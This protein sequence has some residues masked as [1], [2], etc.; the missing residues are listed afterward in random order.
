MTRKWLDKKLVQLM[1]NKNGYLS[2]VLVYKLRQNKFPNISSYMKSR[3]ESFNG[4]TETF[5]RM[6]LNIEK[7][8]V[9]KY[10]GMP[11]KYTLGNYKSLGII[12]NIYCSSSCSAKDLD[13]VNKSKQT[14][15]KRYGSL[16][17]N[18][19]DKAKRTCLEKYGVDNPK[20]S[21]QSKKKTIE[22]CLRKY[23]VCQPT[24]LQKVIDITHQEKCILNQQ[25]TKRKNHTFNSSKKED[26]LYNL[27]CDKYGSSD[28]IRQYSENRY[29][30]NCDFYIKSIDTFIELQGMWTHGGHPYNPNSI[31]DQVKLQQWQSKANNGSR[32][33][34]NAIKVWTI[35]D[36]N[37][38]KIA[39]E[40]H[41]NY[42]EVFDSNFEILYNLS[43]L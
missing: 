10:C 22:T 29:P 16:G 36:P 30:F 12:Y 14:K 20:K 18:N 40:N 38:R 7:H 25:A 3:Y 26:K 37:K 9:C 11:T 17:Y 6:K 13:R 27:L 4:F 2:T 39:K 24:Q 1:S 19:R 8:P 32:F 15:L 42:I 5:M 23:G 28:I 43:I 33:Y 31:K 35:S 41:L 21:E 34:K